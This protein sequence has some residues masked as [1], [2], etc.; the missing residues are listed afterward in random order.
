MYL[1]ALPDRLC[2]KSKNTT[3]AQV[4]E[5]KMKCAASCKC[6]AI[7][8]PSF[9]FCVIKLFFSIALN[10]DQFFLIHYVEISATGSTAV[11]K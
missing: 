1:W 7:F 8:P 11:C 3:F 5:Q 4:L 6:F 2:R 9:F 10:F